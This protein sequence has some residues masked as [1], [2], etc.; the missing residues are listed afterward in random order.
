M[1]PP[2]GC[3]SLAATRL[4]RRLLCPASLERLRHRANRGG[5]RRSR[6]LPQR[7]NGPAAT[8]PRRRR[9]ARAAHLAPRGVT[10]ALRNPDRVSLRRRSHAKGAVASAFRRK[11]PGLCVRHNAQRTHPAVP[12]RPPDRASLRR[13]PPT[14]SP[15][16]DTDADLLVAFL[17][18]AAHVPG[19]YAGGVTFPRTPAEAAAAIARAQRILPIGAQSSLTGGATPRG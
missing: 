8:V 14:T 2:E 4:L 6:K 15:P 7:G 3:L 18:D 17:S 19:G 9:Q 12:E 10:A 1:T 16:I 5:R 11:S 13:P